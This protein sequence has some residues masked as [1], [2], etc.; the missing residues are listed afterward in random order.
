[1]L[2]DFTFS[3]QIAS[4]LKNCEC[5]QLFGTCKVNNGLHTKNPCID[6]QYN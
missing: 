4:Q 3:G 1:M 2:F 5:S 6:G